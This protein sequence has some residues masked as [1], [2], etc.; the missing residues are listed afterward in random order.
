MKNLSRLPSEK[1]G[2]DCWFLQSVGCQLMSP[3]EEN[4]TII[5]RRLSLA[6]LQSRT[7]TLGRRAR[8]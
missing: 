5:A 2:R 4:S 1:R 7:R 8:R 6:P 3:F